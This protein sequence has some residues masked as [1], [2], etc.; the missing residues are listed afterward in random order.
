VGVET[1]QVDQPANARR[2]VHE[3]DASV[4]PAGAGGGIEQHVQTAGVDERHVM[5]IADHL[6]GV[7]LRAAEHVARVVGGSDVE[8]ADHR[9]ADGA[10]VDGM[11]QAEE[12]WA[13]LGYRRVGEWRRHVD[14]SITNAPADQK[15]RVTAE[16]YR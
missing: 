12:P 3:S 13:G 7:G 2:R 15:S 8:L 11:A 14:S 5:E 1:E 6:G 4:V 16:P 9:D 10:R